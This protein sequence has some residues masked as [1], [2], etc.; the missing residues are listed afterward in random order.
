MSLTLVA[1]L[2][3]PGKSYA[4]TR[5][6]FGWI[7]LES[8]AKKHGLSWQKESAFDA[9]VA[10]WNHPH[11]VRWLVKPQTFMNAS[12]RSVQAVAHFHKLSA[13]SITVVYDD[14]TIELGRIKVTVTGSAGGHNG[15]LSLL[16]HVGEGFARFRL[17]IGPK[18]PKEMDMKD[19]VLGQFSHSQLSLIDQ[20]LDH[21]VQSLELLLNEGPLKA[22]NHIN[23]KL[24][25]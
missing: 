22:M 25:S 18:E 1:A 14:I 19:F 12:G 4:N 17:G 11:G 23:R 2:G 24:D 3:N 21:T 5:H 15:I 20:T 13:E 8:L 6:N 9:L 7:V 10:R 16:E